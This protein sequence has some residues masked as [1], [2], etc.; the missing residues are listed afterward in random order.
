MRRTESFTSDITYSLSLVIFSIDVIYII[1]NYIE[2]L[3]RK[4][5]SVHR[6]ELSNTNPVETISSP[7]TRNCPLSTRHRWRSN[8]IRKKKKTVTDL[9][10]F[11]AQK[12]QSSTLHRTPSVW[13]VYVVLV[14][15]FIINI[16]AFFS[17]LRLLAQVHQFITVRTI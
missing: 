1:N 9:I 12:T 8:G 7:S 15:G 10:P 3:F 11:Y 6:P 16:V 17:L 2:T 13:C 4:I 14:P 5:V